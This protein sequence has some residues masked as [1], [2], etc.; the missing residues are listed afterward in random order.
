[1]SLKPQS[2][3]KDFNLRKIDKE[4]A[5]KALITLIYNSENDTIRENS[6]KILGK[7]GYNTSPLF[8]IFED[9]LVSDLNENIRISAFKVL[10]KNFPSE[11]IAPILYAIGRENGDFLVLL[12]E[13][14]GRLNISII[15]KFLIK[16]I[17]TFDKIYLEFFLKEDD[18][19]NLDFI[20]LKEMIFNYV[21]YDSFKSLYF[22]RHKI[23]LALDFYDLNLL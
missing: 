3:L 9:L 19:K 12:I 10:K 22:H 17:K 20:E 11:A 16:K 4:T 1:M 13:V 15:N 2:I 21:M 8:K 18:L 23:L 5:I 14:S 7:L 6:I